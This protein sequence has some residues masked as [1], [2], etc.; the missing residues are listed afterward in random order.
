MLGP[1]DERGSEPQCLRQLQECLLRPAVPGIEAGLVINGNTKG[2]SWEFSLA[3]CCQQRFLEL[4][5]RLLLAMLEIEGRYLAAWMPE[6]V[7]QRFFPQWLPFLPV[8]AIGICQFLFAQAFNLRDKGA[9]DALRF[10]LYFLET[11]PLI[12]GE[13]LAVDLMDYLHISPDRRRLAA[14][15]R[16]QLPSLQLFPE[17]DID[18]EVFCRPG[19]RRTYSYSL[20]IA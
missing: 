9:K 17:H 10:L 5:G 4:Q 14:H 19:V 12:A 15:C 13:C 20:S 11:V 7:A 1:F 8:V 6:P 2:C 16:C 18:Q 3:Y